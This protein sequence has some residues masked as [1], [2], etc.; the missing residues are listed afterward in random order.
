[1]QGRMG[2]EG[3]VEK[4]TR[5]IEKEKRLRKLKGGGGRM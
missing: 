3:K 1:M 2:L 5:R 4:G